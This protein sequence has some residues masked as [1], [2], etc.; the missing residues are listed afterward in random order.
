ML[1]CAFFFEDEEVAIWPTAMP[2]TASQ[3]RNCAA[4]WTLEGKPVLRG[5]ANVIP[6]TSGSNE[7]LIPNQ[8]L[9]GTLFKPLHLH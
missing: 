5:I 7:L 4:G 1:Q 3:I 6:V 8:M 9:F 2:F